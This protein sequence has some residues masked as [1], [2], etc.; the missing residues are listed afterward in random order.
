MGWQE[1]L[2]KEIK[3]LGTAA[4]YFAAWIAAMLLIK[5]L[6]LAEYRIAA[7]NWSMIVVGALVLSKVV[8]ILEHVS[9][10]A[11][12]RA[13]RPGW[14]CCCAPSSILWALPSYCSWKKD[15]RGVTS[16]AASALP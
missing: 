12:V 2:K 3:A 5:T 7:S 8:L 11:W 10:C 9:L 15:S 16:T 1:K 13:L 4:V 14:T 6:I